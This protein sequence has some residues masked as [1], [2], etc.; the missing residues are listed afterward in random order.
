MDYSFTVKVWLL[1]TRTVFHQSHI[2]VNF[3]NRKRVLIYFCT[4]QT[5]LVRRNLGLQ[6]IRISKFLRVTNIPKFRLTRVNIFQQFLC[7]RLQYKHYQDSDE[8]SN[9]YL[10]S[11]QCNHLY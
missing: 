6:K 11:V 8:L 5:T 7:S 9:S 3:K 10:H 1:L 4:F 2:G